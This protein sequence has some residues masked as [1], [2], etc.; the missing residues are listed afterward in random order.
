MRVHAF[1]SSSIPVNLRA[2]RTLSAFAVKGDKPKEAIHLTINIEE[3]E[4]TR[5]NHIFVGVDLHKQ[6]HTAVIMNGFK[7]KLGEIQF[8]NNPNAFPELMKEVKKHLTHGKKAIFGLEDKGG[9]GRALA[10]FLVEQKQIV[11]EINAAIPNGL[12]K[13]NTFYQKSDSLDAEYVGSV[14][15]DRLETL[16]D[17]NPNDFYWEISQLV[18]K[19]KN[20]ANQL[21]A[22]VQQLHV[23]ISHHYSSCKKFFSDLDG[24]TSL[25]FFEQFPAPHHLADTTVQE[26]REILRK[27]S[28][29]A[30]SLNH[31]ERIIRLV[32][33]DGSTK[34]DYQE[35]RDFLIQS[36]IRQ[37][38][39]LKKEQN[40]MDKRLVELMKLTGY[41]LDTMY[42]IDLVTAAYFVAEI[43]D[44]TRFANANKL[45]RYAGIAPVII[46]SGD[47]H[48]KKKCRLGNRDT[49][50]LF[51]RLAC[52]QIGTKK[53]SKEP[54]NRYYYDYYHKKMQE[55]K[56]KHQAI[57]CVMRKL[58]D[59]IY[60]LMKNKTE[61]VKPESCAK[62]AG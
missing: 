62:L 33:E 16:P 3:H 53:G 41:K 31:A 57:V 38:H 30:C 1:S 39:F 23:Q 5:L 19:R 15:V 47:N 12:R 27:P 9:Y 56:T 13:A 8:H 20:I 60:S 10:V 32:Q 22:L 7:R 49:H 50:D 48:K 36:H 59:V 25:A 11:K 4:Q 54:N 29:N 52:R 6:H 40:E 24:K 34:R 14:L 35:E 46:G 42:G 26:L 61:Y 37:M 45:A 51:Y 28:N 55:G 44:I 43:G 18:M 58:V 2:I 21:C 17:A